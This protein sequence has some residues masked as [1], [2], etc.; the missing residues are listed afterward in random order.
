VLDEN[1]NNQ[2]VD[3]KGRKISIPKVDL[4]PDIPKE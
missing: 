3:K 1:G 4:N 2:F